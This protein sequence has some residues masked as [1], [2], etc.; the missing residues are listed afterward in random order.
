M[1]ERFGGSAVTGL[2]IRG[3]FGVPCRRAL[4]SDLRAHDLIPWTIVLAAPH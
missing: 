2:S 3:G 4:E 1:D